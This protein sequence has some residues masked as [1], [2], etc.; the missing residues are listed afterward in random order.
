MEPAVA[1]VDSLTERVMPDRSGQFAFHLHPDG[2]RRY[3]RIDRHRGRIRITADSPVSL[4]SGLRRYMRDYLHSEVSWTDFQPVAPERLPLPRGR[5]VARS[6][7]RFVT[8]MN[9][10]TYG[11]STVYWDWERW[12]REIDWM[13]LHG[14]T[15]PL[16]TLGAECVWRDFLVAQGYTDA[17]ARAFLTAPVY[18]PWLLMGNMERLGGPMSEAWL[19]RQLALARRVV[20]RMRSLGMEPIFQGFYGMVPGD[21]GRR[22]PWRKVVDQGQWNGLERPDILSPLDA[23]FD[24][25]AANWYGHYERLLGRGRY[26]GGDLFHEGG[27][28]GGLD[29]TACARAVAAAMQKAS[30]GATWVVQGWGNN[31]TPALLAGLDPAHAL[32]VE[33][34]GEY[35]HRWA[36]QG[37]YAGM[38]W[39]WSNISN[40]GGNVG[41]HGRLEAIATEAPRALSDERAG[42]TLAGIGFT[43]EGIETNP[44]VASLWA[45]M[46][47]TE[48][49]VDVTLWA[50]HYP[51]YR[52]GIRSPRLQAAWREFA[53]TAYA[54]H[55]GHRRPS[56]PVF[57]AAPSLRVTTVSAWSQC[58]IFY[59]AR[60][61]AAAV[62]TFLQMADSLRDN[63][64]YQYD[65]VDLVRQCLSDQGRDAYADIQQAWAKRD[66]AAFDRSCDRFMTLMADQDG[67]L[68]SHPMFRFDTWQQQARAASNDRTEQ[69]LNDFY[70]RTFVT[71]WDLAN[72]PLN[73]YAHREWSGLLK[74]YYARRWQLFFD[75]LRLKWDAPALPAPDLFAV[76]KTWRYEPE[77][78]APTGDAAHPVDAA[79][80]MYRK[81]FG[82]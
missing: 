70:L 80:R 58:K 74:G 46:V 56:E 63:A 33:L 25:L 45:D 21:F 77:P 40:W 67:L 59:D 57:C 61:F 13:A 34:C 68:S 42:R 48:R 23:S 82:E 52:Y 37:G 31:P 75:Y 17:E 78:A 47:W 30:P 26:F 4:A 65:A 11:Y 79:V 2:E 9:Y 8:Y 1:A 73:D 44:V 62:G 7:Y 22:Y 76:T 71:S 35:W 55:P 36:D 39:A 14:V 6:P 38:P 10:C 29:V 28:S 53:Q 16:V 64:N 69:I 32:V 18:M 54:T 60:R 12:E 19:D 43:P 20:G 27:K 41:L 81:Y 24:S 66:R 50:S 5:V 49:P 3:Y 15:H 51:D 72:G